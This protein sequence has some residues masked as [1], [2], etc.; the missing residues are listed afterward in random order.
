[1][2]SSSHKGAPCCYTRGTLVAGMLFNGVIT[3]T[4]LPKTKIYGTIVQGTDNDHSYQLTH[5]TEYRRK[6]EGD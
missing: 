5:A 3:A 2:D 4:L 1:M 6:K